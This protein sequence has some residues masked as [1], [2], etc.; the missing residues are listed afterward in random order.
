MTTRFLVAGLAAV[1]RVSGEEDPDVGKVPADGEAVQ[2]AGGLQRVPDLLHGAE[3]QLGELMEAPHPPLNHLCTRDGFGHTF[4]AGR[5][6]DLS[7]ERLSPRGPAR[8]L[9]PSPPLLHVAESEAQR[10]T[11]L[12]AVSHSDL[13]RV[14]GEGGERTDGRELHRARLLVVLHLEGGRDRH[15]ESSRHC[16]FKVLNDVIYT[17]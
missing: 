16:S 1:Q 9:G 7:A 17:R 14:G 4:S 5:E 2:A 11:D 13:R 3:L 10:V 8:S 15:Q 12:T 6:D